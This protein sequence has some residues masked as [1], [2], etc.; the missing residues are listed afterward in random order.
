MEK[1]KDIHLAAFFILLVIIVSCDFNNHDTPLSEVDFR[2]QLNQHIPVWMERYGVPG[3]SIALIKNGEMSWS[4]AY[5]FADLEKQTRMTTDTVCRTESISK[6][7]TAR[8]VIRL[9][10]LGE[11]EL[12]DPVHRYLIS[13]EFPESEFKPQLRASFGHDRAGICTGRTKTIFKREPDA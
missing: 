4:D 1:L 6:S 5:G 3:V 2:E 12:D 10:E 11:I 8:G 13:W 7:V 9:V